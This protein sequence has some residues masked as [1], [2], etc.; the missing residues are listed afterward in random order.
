MTRQV[1]ITG[2]EFFNLNNYICSLG[3]TA[4]MMFNI[5]SILFSRIKSVLVL[6]V[7]VF[8]IFGLN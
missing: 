3:V 8:L 6:F 2:S 5:C 7:L 1:I 4:G